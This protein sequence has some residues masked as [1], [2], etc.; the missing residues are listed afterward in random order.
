MDAPNFWKRL[1]FAVRRDPWQVVKA[2]VYSVFVGYTVCWGVMAPLYGIVSDSEFRGWPKYLAFA[3]IGLAFGLLYF[4][5]KHVPRTKVSF[6]LPST[7]TRLTI[8]FGDFFKED[9]HKVIAVSE[10]F[11]GKLGDIVS[12]KS[13]HGQFIAKYLGGQEFAFYSL[14]DPSLVKV[15]SIPT[16]REEGRTRKYAIGATAVGT[17][18]NDKYFFVAL[19]VADPVTHK[20]TADVPDLW[21]ALH[22]LW[23][24]V[25]E[26]AN[27]YPVVLPLI[28]GGI[29]GVGLPD[30]VL[31]N[32]IVTSIVNE[33]KKK[34]I[35]NEIKI[36]LHPS[37]AEQIDLRRIENEWH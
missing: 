27:G 23:H 14:V 18:K 30:C 12:K 8:L 9:G 35:T 1:K 5:A 25:R 26:C 29:S 4:T 15:T 16:Q 21:R 6:L 33:T 19:T 17:I 28:G 32:L 24:V 7:N 31:L 10:F 13:L 20:V 36:V 37:A 11:D 22:G 3:A 34:R 2:A